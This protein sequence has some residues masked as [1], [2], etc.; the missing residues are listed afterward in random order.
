M[1]DP[2]IAS[3]STE[4]SFLAQHQT[5]QPVI[6]VAFY[7]CS[8]FVCSGGYWQLSSTTRS[9]SSRSSY[10]CL[11]FLCP[12][13]WW[14]FSLWVKRFIDEKDQANTSFQLTFTHDLGE[15][16]YCMC[17]V[18]EEQPAQ[19]LVETL[20]CRLHLFQGFSSSESNDFSSSGDQCLFSRASLPALFPGPLVYHRVTNSLNIACGYHIYSVKFSL[21][22][23]L[24]N[25]GKKISVGLQVIH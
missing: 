1:V 25:S 2:G 19:I 22:S 10:Q 16:A 24:S 3:Q 13:P 8:P 4:E 21:L 11:S 12:S 15:H 6:Q 14:R 18:E 7:L 23:S 9:R 20:S 5:D 17:I